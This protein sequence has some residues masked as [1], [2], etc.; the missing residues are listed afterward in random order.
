MEI[1]EKRVSKT[2]V[3]VIYLI[4]FYT[5]WALFEFFAKP[6]IDKTFTGDIISQIIKTVIIKI[7]YGY[8]PLRF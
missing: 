8:F 5:I 4:V 2:K 6:Y 3:I 7:L 1:S